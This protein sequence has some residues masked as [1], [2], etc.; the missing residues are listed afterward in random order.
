MALV[1]FARFLKFICAALVILAVPVSITASCT[2]EIGFHSAEGACTHN[3]IL[4]GLKNSS[5]ESPLSCAFSRLTVRI[6]TP[7]QCINYGRV[8]AF[9]ILFFFLVLPSLCYQA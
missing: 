3:F 6:L 8:D 2:S 9:C 4:D 5:S 7:S 1:L